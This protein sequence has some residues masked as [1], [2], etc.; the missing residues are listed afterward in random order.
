MNKDWHQADIIAA[1]KKKGTTMAAVSRR[2]G[3]SSSTLSNAL[4]RKWPKGER[5]IAEAIGV[6][7]ETIWP[8]RYTE[9]KYN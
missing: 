5:L 8:S 3:L 6:K 2:A 1:I 9:I 4:I 7:A